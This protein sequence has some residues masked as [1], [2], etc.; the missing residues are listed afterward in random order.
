MTDASAP[1]LYE[2]LGG[3]DAIDAIVSDFYGRVLED[4]ELGPI[5][6]DV[7]MGRLRHMQEEF[8]TA[9]FG[10]PDAY[11]GADLR[12]AHARRGITAHHFS[13]FVERFL[14]TLEV[15]DVP[16]AVRERA[17][18]RLALYA[19]EIVGGHGESG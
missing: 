18:D 10:G 2:E 17:G 13:R 9:A 1:T 5:F 6:R 12:T 16:A 14:E 8:L 4:P 3:V 7:D 11:T 19:P 15:R